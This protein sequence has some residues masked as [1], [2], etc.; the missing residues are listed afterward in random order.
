[1]SFKIVAKYR[2]KGELTLRRFATRPEAEAYL[3]RVNPQ[4]WSAPR[5]VEDDKVVAPEAT[6]PSPMPW[7]VKW[8]GGFA[9]MIDANGKTVG[10][11]YGS[12]SQREQ[13]A[14]AIIDMTM[15][16]AAAKL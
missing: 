12:Q 13:N 8:Q 1:M 5:I 11:L 7:S 16:Q 4:F 2:N 9:Y 10:T 15:E 14:G 6:A 3:P